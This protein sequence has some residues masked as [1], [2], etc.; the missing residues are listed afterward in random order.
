MN[1]RDF[2]NKKPPEEYDFT[3]VNPKSDYAQKHGI[4]K[5]VLYKLSAIKNKNAWYYNGKIHY[6]KAYD[7]WQE[8]KNNGTLSQVG[9]DPDIFSKDP[10]SNHQLL[11]CIYEQLWNKEILPNCSDTMNSVQTTFNQLLTCY[12]K[13]NKIYKSRATLK[14][15]AEL[16][17]ENELDKE[18]IHDA[19]ALM[20][21]YHTIGNYIPVPNRVNTWKA[22]AFKDYFDLFLVF[23]YNYYN[24]K[25]ILVENDYSCIKLKGTMVEEFDNWLDKFG[26]WNTFVEKNYLKNFVK[27]NNDGTYGKPKELW[28]GHFGGAVLPGTTDQCNEYF[29][30]AHDWILKR[31]RIMVEAM[32]KRIREME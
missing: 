15:I 14:Y 2:L 8:L 9:K 4:D 13:E 18:H 21:V 1:M 17:Y 7:K 22:N 32:H 16:Y 20:N 29:K 23:I 31:G 24:A 5:Y 6:Q 3:D 10:N 26:S 25:N 28:K 27:K 11:R 12:Y 19:E 30:N